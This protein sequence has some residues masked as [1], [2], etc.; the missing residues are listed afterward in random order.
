M[1]YDRQRSIEIYHRLEAD[2]SGYEALEM[3]A[4]RSGYLGQKIYRYAKRTG[5]KKLAICLDREPNAE[6]TKW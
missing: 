5:V 3:T 6:A 4:R 1:I 2:R